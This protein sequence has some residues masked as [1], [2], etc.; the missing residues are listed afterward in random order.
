MREEFNVQRAKM[1][2]LFLQKEGKTIIH[3]SKYNRN[4]LYKILS[5]MLRIKNNSYEFIFELL[6]LKK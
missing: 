4:K 2:E 6:Q 1:K 5:W 3:I